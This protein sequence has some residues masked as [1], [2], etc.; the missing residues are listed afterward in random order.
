MKTDDVFILC[1]RPERRI[2]WDEMSIGYCENRC[3]YYPSCDP[4]LMVRAFIREIAQ[5]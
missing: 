2:Y 5:C 4:V 1:P 3:K